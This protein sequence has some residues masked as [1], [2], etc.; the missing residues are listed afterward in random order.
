MHSIHVIGEHRNWRRMAAA[1]LLALVATVAAAQG[2]DLTKS[3]PPAPYVNAS[4]I[5]PLPDFI[6]GAGALFIDPANAP[7]GPWLAY[8][9]DGSLVEVL[10]MVPISQM[11]AATNWSDLAAGLLAQIGLTVDHVD[12]TYNGGHP[13]MAEP[14][15][16]VRL[17]FVDAATQQ[18]AL[19]P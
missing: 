18:A 15:Y 7:V 4:T 2:G 16:H 17:A 13:G 14:H 6:P 12:I 8:G 19:N 10:F 9:S 11:Q 5:L 1:L 3:P